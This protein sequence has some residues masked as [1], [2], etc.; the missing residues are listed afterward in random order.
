LAKKG[1]TPLPMDAVNYITKI[2]DEILARRRSHS[3]RRNDFM[4]IM[5]D[6]EEEVK[7]EEQIEQPTEQSREQGTVLKKSMSILNAHIIND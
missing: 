5:V 7:D 3:E 2:V 4:Q 1:Y 6:R